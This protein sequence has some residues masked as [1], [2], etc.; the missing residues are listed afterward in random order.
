M[1]YQPVDEAAGCGARTQRELR[2]QK[3]LEATATESCNL[4]LVTDASGAL[5]SYWRFE[6]RDAAVVEC[7]V[8]SLTRGVAFALGW[9]IER[10][11]K[12][13]QRESLTNTL[14]LRTK[15]SMLE[16]DRTPVPIWTA[17]FRVA[18]H[19]HQNHA[20]LGTFTREP[21]P[22]Y[23]GNSGWYGRRLLPLFSD[24]ECELAAARH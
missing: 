13:F 8:I 18:L 5:Y 20:T 2:K 24:E 22:R 9:A 17:Y 15:R 21:T 10:S 4:I 1:R 19:S 23:S 6:E 7:R 12:S 14:Q 3:K 16:L 11:S